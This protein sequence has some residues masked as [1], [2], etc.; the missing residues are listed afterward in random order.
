MKH[1]ISLAILLAA[2]T[3]HAD[4]LLFPNADFE[5]G[6]LEGWTVEGDAF[7][8]QPTKGDNTAAR[9]REPANMQG[10]WWIGG[11]E[12]YNGKEG[13]PGETA[14]DSLTGTLT[15]REFTI[16][17]PY[18]T[19]RVGAGHLP[20]KV[21]VN[22][23]VDGKVIELATG[24][25]DESMVMHSSDVKA[26]VGKSAQLQ[27]FD[28][29]TG[30]WGHINADDFR[31]TE[32]PSPDTTKEFAFTGDISAT[33][34]P[35]VGYDQPNRPQ[36][37]FMSKKNWLNDPNGMVYDGKNYHLFF[38]H[39]P[40]GTDW[41]N[42]TWGHA[43]SP[44]MVHWTQL[45]HALLPYRVDRQAGTVFSGTAVIDHNNSLG[46][47]VGDTKTMCAFYT[48]AG[49]PA[50]YQA[51]AYS[52]DSGASWTYWNE[53]RAVVE[54]QG[55]DNGER[56]P[57]VFWHEPSQHWVMALWVGE[58]PGRVRWFTSKNLVDWEFASDLMRDW[59]FECMD[60]VFLPVD[61][62]ENNMKCLIYDAS[63]D[64]EIGT[65]D[66]KE[67]KTETEALQI[68]R[69]NFYA[70]QTFNQAP[71]GRVVQIGWMRGGP[72]A[73]E[74][75]DVPHNQQMAFPCDL[76]L[77]TTDDGVR[78]FVSPISEIDSLV[79]KTHDLGQVKLSDGINALSGIQ[80][81]DLVDLEVTFSPGNASEVV[82]DL[83]RVSVRYDV[84]KQVLNHTGVNDKGESELQICIDKLSSKQGKVSLRLLVDRLTVEA[85][86]FDGQNFGAHY[87]HPNHG[88]KT[89]SIHSVGGDALIHDLKIRELKST[90]KN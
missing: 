73:A 65:F 9:N 4:E 22:L 7:R 83:P 41:G 75:F 38:Q 42:M 55:F 28:N 74:T 34:Y 44:D 13:K 21:G 89:M 40:K 10:T 79:S 43:T 52:T 66:G 77:K 56:D 60:V 49:K 59:A 50:F 82:F 32:K 45:D 53:G 1:F 67:F 37:H 48:F 76:S 47:Q 84:K 30:G 61:G 18:I 19:F 64:Y 46:K 14:G 12:K 58:K 25:D 51:M 62:D 20:G 8:V 6:T 24:V 27:I 15:S 33:A 17:R 2:S 78:L 16:E 80:N 31:G 71:N 11:Y 68:G 57:K 90:W 85:F 86:A 26:Y 63:F 54:N 23:L 39:N 3:V 36:F 72:N 70:A 5:S 88:P 87:I 35:D 29:A 81:L 69:G